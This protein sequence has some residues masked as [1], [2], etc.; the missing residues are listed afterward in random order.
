MHVEIE[1]IEEDIP[2]SAPAS[3]MP[4]LSMAHVT[5]LQAESASALAK[6]VKDGQSSAEKVLEVPDEV[7]SALKSLLATGCLDTVYPAACCVS[8][9]A[10]LGEA[11]SIL[12]H[13]GLLQALALQAIAELRKSQGLVGTGLA[14]AVQVA[15]QCCVGSLTLAVAQELQSILLNAINDELLQKNAVACGHLQQAWLDTKLVV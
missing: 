12:A 2:A 3:I 11:T 13:D 8:D 1:A 6:I 14:H 15:V 5:G 10:V 4:Q 7:A 9:L